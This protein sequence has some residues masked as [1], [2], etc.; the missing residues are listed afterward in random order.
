MK[1]HLSHKNAIYLD[2]EAIEMVNYSEN[3][4]ILE[5]KFTNHKK[6]WYKNVP[7]T[8]WQEFVTV[9]KAGLSAGAY[10]NRKIKPVYEFEEVTA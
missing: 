7:A 10:F 9:I 2:S 1:K 6:Y 8:I 5:A 4:H 3:K